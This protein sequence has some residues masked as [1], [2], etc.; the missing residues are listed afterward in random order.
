MPLRVIESR[1]PPVPKFSIAPAQVL[2]ASLDVNSGSEQIAALSRGRAEGPGKHRFPIPQ[3]T[4]QPPR[5]RH[6][7]RAAL[8]LN[9]ADFVRPTSTCIVSS[10]R[11]AYELS[12]QA[13]S[14]ISSKMC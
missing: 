8:C 13:E 7:Q 6:A 1:Y 12:E 3:Q 2:K 9:V 11:S 10:A 5:Q 14:I 4:V